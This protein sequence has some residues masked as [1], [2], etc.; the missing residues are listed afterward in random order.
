MRISRNL[1]IQFVLIVS[2]ILPSVVFAQEQPPAQTG[3]PF[4]Q[5]CALPDAATTEATPSVEPVAEATAA[6]EAT[7]EAA[8][9]IQAVG[10]VNAPALEATDNV[11]F[12]RFVHTSIDSGP[13]D[14]YSSSLGGV[15]LVANF[16]FDQ[17]TDVICVPAGQHS[18]EFRPAGSDAGAEPTVSVSWDFSQDTSWMI[19]VAGRV[20]D[21]SLQVEPFTLLREDMNG[22]ARVRVV[23]WVSG[24]ESMTL[25]SDEEVDFGT[26]LGWVGMKDADI[27]AGVYHLN[28]TSESG[29]AYMT[30]APY[31]F[32]ANTLY[33]VIILGGA[34]GNP[35][36]HIL[37]IPVPQTQTRVRFV[38]NRAEAVDILMRPGNAVLVSALAPGA[39]T[40]YVVVPNGAVTFVAYAPTTGPT[41]QELSAYIGQ[42]DPQRDVTVALQSDGSMALTETSWT[43]R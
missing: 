26:G 22:N 31:E 16:Q 39:T 25:S 28:L 21:V 17:F 42:L 37:A 15:L 34:D 4:T 40:D 36:P 29:Q 24:A 10:V 1:L 11:A 12:I 8:Q 43:P 5:S 35:A 18:F 30:A 14:V 7:A 32:A 38:N 41:G 23:N 9:P 6:A 19:A 33:A 3:S 20:A 27:P 2:L 13:V